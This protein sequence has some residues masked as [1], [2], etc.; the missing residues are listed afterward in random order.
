MK[1]KTAAKKASS[2]GIS[3][4][5]SYS[6]TLTRIISAITALLLLP[7]CS[8]YTI[9]HEYTIDPG[10]NEHRSRL[11]NA[12]QDRDLMIYWNDG[13]SLGAKELSMSSDSL[14]VRGRSVKGLFRKDDRRKLSF[15]YRQ[16]SRI[17]V[18]RGNDGVLGTVAGGIV[19]ITYIYLM[20]AAIFRAFPRENSS[21]DRGYP[22]LSWPII[23]TGLLLGCTAG[24]IIGEA[25]TK[26]DVYHLP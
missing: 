20:Y 13:D 19:G 21:G 2:L 26:W 16:M 18:C 14:W 22:R 15:S 5:I 7:G 6:K 23:S 25:Q 24:L 3:R 8:S 12:A 11:L 10:A 4:V 9:L 1:P 17:G